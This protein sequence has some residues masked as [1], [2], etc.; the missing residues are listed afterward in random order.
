[1]PHHKPYPLRWIT[2]DVNLQVTWKYVFRFAITANFVDEVELDVVS[3]DIYVIV[4]RSMYLYD[5]KVVFH[6]VENK[7]HLFKY[8][9]EYI[10]RSHRR[11]L[12]LYLASAGKMKR[13]VNSNKSLVL[14][15]IK[16]KKETEHGSFAVC[17]VNL[18]FELVDV[19]N[20]YGDMF[21]KPKG[22]PPKRGIQHDIH[23]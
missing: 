8:G 19:V 21:Q 9:V 7:Y 12:N 18:K 14:L 5:R 13:L 10:V 1:M 3:L 11:K 23:L 15:M 17:D 16:Q 6:I 22:L 2:K 4:L 20:Q